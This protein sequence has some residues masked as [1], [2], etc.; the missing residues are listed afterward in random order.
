MGKDIKELKIVSELVDGGKFFES[1]GYSIVKVTRAGEVEHVKLPIKTTGIAEYQETLRGKAPRPP[2]T[3]KL[4]KKDSREGRVMGLAHDQMMIV[5]D[6]TD[7][8]FVDAMEA[9]NQ[10]FS[11]RICVFALD[12]VFKDLQGNPVESYED[13]K[14]ILQNNGITD[15]QS[16]QIFNDVQALTQMDEVNAD[17]L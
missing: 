8:K 2:Q 11:W 16:M 3:F 5:F 13:K 10:D 7:E 9:H 14:R 15:H 17:F 4:V 1:H 6:T 12:M